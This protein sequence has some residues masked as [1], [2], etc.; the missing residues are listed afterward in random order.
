[1]L[2]AGLRDHRKWGIKP[3]SILGQQLASKGPTA[4]I[5]LLPLGV[6]FECRGRSNSNCVWTKNYPKKV[7]LM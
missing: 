6:I 2:L 7:F 4:V 1:M 5:S 3:L